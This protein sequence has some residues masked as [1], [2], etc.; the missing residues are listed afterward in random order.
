[1]WCSAGV[2]ARTPSWICPAPITDYG[3][4]KAAAETAVM[5]ACPGAVVVRTSLIYGTQQLAPIQLDVRAAVTGTSSMTFFTDEV[6]CP[7]HAT[8]LATAVADLAGRRDI[9]GPLHVAGPEAIDRASLARL[10]ARWMGHDPSAVRTGS[11]AD[12]A[13]VRPAHV[14][15]DVTHAATMGI[16]CRPVSEV[17][18]V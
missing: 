17:L 9:T 10:I 16:R 5:D 18:G 7:V 6:R 11:T 3:R 14:V 2:L 1:M 12:A 8:D 13:Q 4:W 15:L